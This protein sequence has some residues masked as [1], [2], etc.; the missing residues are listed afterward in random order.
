MKLLQRDVCAIGKTKD[1]EP[2]F[3]FP[4]FPV[5]MGCVM[6]PKKDDLLEDMHWC[7]SKESGLIQLSKLIP[8]DLLYADAHGSGAVGNIWKKHHLEF[9]K[10]I[11]KYGPRSVL[12]IGGAHGILAH[13][14]YQLDPI[15]WTILEP[16]PTPIPE[17]KA[18]YIVGFLDENFKSSKTYDAIV[19]SHVL[20]HLY[21]PFGLIKLI[22]QITEPGKHLIFSLPN[23]KAMIE[24]KYTN[25]LN[26]EHS[27]FLTEPYIDFMLSKCGFEIVEKKYYLRDHSIFYAAIKKPGT[28]LINF[29]GAELY[30][31]NKNIFLE[32]INFYKSMVKHI[33]KKIEDLDRPTYLFGA[34]IFS[35]F[36]IAFGLDPKKLLNILD[37]DP[38]KHEKRLYGTSLHVSSPEILRGIPNPVVILHA[39]PYNNEIKNKILK[40]INSE[41]IFI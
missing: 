3:T 13:N 1:L 5:L 35:Q 36:L 25:A 31:L 10:F 37:N 28:K 32:Y 24:S 26:F 4:S 16:K 7:I 8:L 40:D 2:L 21:D 23:L 41:C 20:E 39:G 34:H 14:Y 18:E 12:E 29:D 38:A 9:A 19:H 6:Q 27:I 22:S 17:N 30:S 15:A 11:N 33:S